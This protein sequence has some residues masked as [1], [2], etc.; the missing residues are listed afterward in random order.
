MHPA[1][2][3]LLLHT[4]RLAVRQELPDDVQAAIAAARAAMAVRNS[5]QRSPAAQPERGLQLPEQQPNVEIP[6]AVPVLED[7]AG[8]EEMPA[9]E[10]VLVAAAGSDP[11]PGPTVVV[12]P[13]VPDTPRAMPLQD[14][15]NTPDRQA[16]G[17]DSSIKP[18]VSA[19]SGKP[20]TPSHSSSSSGVVVVPTG[21]Q[22][23]HD[24]ENE[25][26]AAVATSSGCVVAQQQQPEQ[27]PPPACNAA[28]PARPPTVPASPPAATRMRMRFEAR[29]RAQAG[30]L[31][32]LSV[33]TGPESPPPMPLGWGIGFGLGWPSLL[34]GPF[35]LGLPLMHQSY[36]HM[37]MQQ[38]WRSGARLSPVLGADL[39]GS[40]AGAAAAASA[41]AAESPHYQ[42]QMAP[43]HPQQQQHIMSELDCGEHMDWDPSEQA[44]RYQQEQQQREELAAAV[45]LGMPP[46]RTQHGQQQ[47]AQL[48][49]ALPLPQWMHGGSPVAAAQSLALAHQ[50]LLHQH[51]QQVLRGLG[52]APVLQQQGPM[53]PALAGLSCYQQLLASASA[54]AASTAAT[55]SIDNPG[56]EE[57]TR[58]L[59]SASA[60][61]AC[62]EL[63]APRSHRASPYAQR[64]QPGAVV[65]STT[66]Q[67]VAAQALQRRERGRFPGASAVPD[68]TSPRGASAHAF[69]MDTDDSENCAPQQQRHSKGLLMPGE[70]R[71]AT[72]PPQGLPSAKRQRPFATANVPTTGP[73]G[74][75]PYLRAADAMH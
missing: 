71:V 26:L 63:A 38:H 36:S 13:V 48:R 53:P 16:Y 55:K 72:E 17:C 56:G 52:A 70:P 22:A 58:H 28:Q 42:Q 6:A 45:H 18:K 7:A 8:L 60:T 2:R 74:N 35:P 61:T 24:K 40:P 67:L 66:R 30:K 57:L 15:S 23:V 25:P 65:G 69:A 21:Q 44:R 37:A 73:R 68:E 4:Q 41:A 10:A 50:L 46:I 3:P 9:D 64:Q 33:R 1:P 34:A 32:P 47:Q 54:C 14:R 12:V 5:P 75:A 49:S 39:P 51:Q 19:H 29:L 59:A 31:H 62:P 27:P 20:D 43:S 11:D